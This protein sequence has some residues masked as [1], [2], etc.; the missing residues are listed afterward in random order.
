MIVE[1]KF[2]DFESKPSKIIST[3]W[4]DLVVRLRFIKKCRGHFECFRYGARIEIREHS[5]DEREETLVLFGI[6]AAHSRGAFSPLFSRL[7]RFS[8][9]E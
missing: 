9:L 3:K 6:L 7:P 1:K 5:K 8:R 2:I 4:L